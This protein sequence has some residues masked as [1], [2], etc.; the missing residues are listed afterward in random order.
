MRNAFK[1][2]VGKPESRKPLRRRRNRWEDNI[3]P[4]KPSGNY[5]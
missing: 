2:V 1:V 5:M 4:L 3:N